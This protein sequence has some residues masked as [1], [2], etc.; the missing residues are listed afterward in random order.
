MLI[1][2]IT[3]IEPHGLNKVVT[4]EWRARKDDDKDGK[5]DVHLMTDSLSVP[6][7][8][9]DIDIKARIESRRREILRDTPV[10]WPETDMNSKLLDQ[11]V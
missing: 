8:A 6:P 9:S 10:I 7:L 5:S 11:E 3:K 2:K 1:G 4:V